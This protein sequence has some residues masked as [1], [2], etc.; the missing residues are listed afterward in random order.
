[1][2][3]INNNKIQIGRSPEK[4]NEIPL[5]AEEIRQ[6]LYCKRVIYYRRVMNF[7]GK[8]SYLMEKG[9][10]YQEMKDKYAYLRKDDLDQIKNKYFFNNELNYGAKVDL[11]R[12]RSNGIISCEFKRYRF[13]GKT[14]ISHIYQAVIGGLAAESSLQKPLLNIEITYWKGTRTI[15]TVTDE[16]RKNSI[17]LLNDIRLMIFNEILPDPTPNKNKCRNC[18]YFSICLGI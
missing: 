18:E 6:Y 16:M 2:N 14:P 10:E 11:I 1:M 17:N 7:K 15:L 9:E 3:K 4:L 8:K 5:N 12:I 13:P